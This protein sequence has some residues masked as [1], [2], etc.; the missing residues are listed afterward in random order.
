MDCEWL[1]EAYHRLR[2][3]SAPG[4]NGQ[5]VEE[6]GENL[7]ENIQ[8]LLDRAKS[9]RYYAPPVRRVHIP[10][11]MGKETRPIGVPE[12]EDKVLQRAVVMILNP[13][14][15]QDFL[16]C[17]HGYRNGRSAHD[18]LNAIREQCLELGIKWIVDIDIRKFFDT[19]NHAYLRKFLQHRVCDGVITRLI[20]KRLKAGV[21]EDGEVHYPEDGTPQGGNISPL[22]S[23]IYLHYVIDLWFEK[24]VK[25]ELKGRAFMV[26]FADDM[27]MGFEFKEDAE[28]VMRALPKRLGKF[29]L[30]LHSDKTRI[31]SFARPTGKGGCRPGTFDFL[32]FTHYWGKSRW[33]KWVIKRKTAS[34]RLNRALK[35]TGRWCKMN[36]HRSI[37]EQHKGLCRKL[38]GHCAYY[39]ITGNGLW[40][41][42]YREGMLKL[43]RKWLN[44]RT[45]KP[46]MTWDKFSCLLKHYPIP[47]ARVVHSIYIAKP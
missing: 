35:R 8:N 38:R 30:S 24:V 29:G 31:L 33:N 43:W 37:T 44:R 1:A 20:G 28:R 14:Y 45:S 11:D 22:L 17:S 9:G 2:K 7:E 6:Y 47:S 4:C 19:L 40:L 21:I 41:K 32:G 39:G 23:N 15:E 42:K 34:S 10:K 5:T 36:R 13:I 16:E 12:T 18:A 27:V 25:P 3:D 46:S 26:R